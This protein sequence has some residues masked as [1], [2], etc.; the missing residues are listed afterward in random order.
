MGCVKSYKT[1]GWQCL[2]GDGS[3]LR[4]DDYIRGGQEIVRY[5]NRVI[6]RFDMQDSGVVYAKW[7]YPQRDPFFKAAASWCKRLLRGPRVRHIFN[8]HQDMQENGIGCAA[9]LLAAWRFPGMTELFVCSEVAAPQVCWLLGEA[10]ESGCRRLLALAA[11]GMR[12]LH[13]AGFIHGDAVPGNMCL[14]EDGEIFW[15]DNDRTRRSSSRNLALRNV[16]QFCSRLF[17]Y[18]SFRMAPDIFVEEYCGNDFAPEDIER[19]RRRVTAR[20]EQIQKEIDK[21][22][23]NSKSR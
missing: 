11:A 2:T 1:D 4:P 10:D 9:P 19:L 22:K 21:K 5:A 23:R 6:I 3:G 14:A 16:V 7:L 15:L 13:R 17:R 18:C 12:K 8:I 20:I